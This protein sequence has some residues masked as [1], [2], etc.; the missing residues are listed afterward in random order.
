MKGL[1]EIIPDKVEGVRFHIAGE[2]ICVCC[3]Y[4]CKG[5]QSAYFKKQEIIHFHEGKKS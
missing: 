5:P 3:Q 4:K 2:R 1:C